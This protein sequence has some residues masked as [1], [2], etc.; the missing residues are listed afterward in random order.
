MCILL[1][2]LL[3]GKEN[4]DFILRKYNTPDNYVLSVVYRNRATHHLLRAPTEEPAAFLNKT[5]GVKSQLP[6]TGI[7]NVRNIYSF[8]AVIVMLLA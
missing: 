5:G 4:G 8:S 7:A 1:A 6:V 3:S 2:A